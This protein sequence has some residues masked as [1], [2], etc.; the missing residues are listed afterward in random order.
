[1]TNWFFWCRRSFI[2]VVSLYV[3][4]LMDKSPLKLVF[5]S[6]F[7]KLQCLWHIVLNLKCTPLTIKLLICAPISQHYEILRCY[8]PWIAHFHKQKPFPNI[9]RETLKMCYGEKCHNV[10]P[11]FLHHTMETPLFYPYQSLGDNFLWV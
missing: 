6:F 7:I 3:Q 8:P 10:T 9:Y 4:S 11:S 5:W 2:M 1:V